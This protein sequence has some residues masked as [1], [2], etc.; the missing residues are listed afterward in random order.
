[1]T[2]RPK[3][4]CPDCKHRQSKCK[5]IF[6]VEF[7]IRRQIDEKGRLT[8]TKGVKVTYEQNWSAYNKAQT[9]EKV[10]FYEVVK[11]FV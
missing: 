11:R 10:N 9:N 3:C 2:T 1:M 8:E 5:H 4:N 7:Y 6:A